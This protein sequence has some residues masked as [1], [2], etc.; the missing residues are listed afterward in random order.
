MKFIHTS[1]I[2]LAKVVD[3]DYKWT[4][5]R[6]KE[7]YKTFCDIIN[8]CNVEGVDLLLISGNLFDKQP[9]VAELNDVNDVFKR[10]VK[11]KVC[12]IAGQNDMLIASSN[13]NTFSWNDNVFMAKSAGYDLFEIEE[14]G[15]KIYAISEGLD[16]GRADS[17]ECDRS[18]TN[19]LIC[20]KADEQ[21]INMDLVV[22]EKSGFDYV[23]IGGRRNYSKVTEN[24]VIA[25]S[26]EPLEIGDIGEHGIIIGEINEHNL[27]YEFKDMCSRKYMDIV[28][29]IDDTMSES[30][31]K[32]RIVNFII[33]NGKDNIYT[34]T[35]EGYKKADICT[36]YK[37]TCDEYNI[38]NITDKT[39][40]KYDF[41]KLQEDNED[42]IIGKFIDSINKS[43]VDDD[44]KKK[45]LY[46]GMEAL[47]TREGH[48]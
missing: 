32:E 13:Y 36:D 43:E 34:V 3:K 10:L 33:E 19:I 39:V 27:T 46:Y 31:I 30:E 20:N 1:D 26:P 21:D 38:V 47:L 44:I 24:T 48:R 5:E 40:K 28:L 16:V 15:T 7:F 2:H 11:T 37:E 23:A 4:L 17:F 14:I 29:T 25:G 35:L 9:T 6:G 18:F 8:I 45:A 41:I 12:L 22:A 42:N